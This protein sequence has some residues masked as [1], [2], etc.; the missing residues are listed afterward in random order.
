MRRKRA[1]RHVAACRRPVANVVFARVA[2]VLWLSFSAI[3]AFVR[4]DYRV[5]SG[6]EVEADVS[7]ELGRPSC[8]IF[9][10]A[11]RN[12]RVRRPYMSRTEGMHGLQCS[13]SV[14]ERCARLAFY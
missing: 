5:H 11:P 7:R 10:F 12:S 3:Q 8:E 6:E 14:G 1:T 13:V 2:A 4:E 9:G